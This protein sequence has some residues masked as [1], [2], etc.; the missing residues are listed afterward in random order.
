MELTD[1]KV[2]SY[3]FTESSNGYVVQVRR[4]SKAN[5]FI[6]FWSLEGDPTCWKGKADYPT[7]Q[8]C[9]NWLGRIA[10]V[11][12]AKEKAEMLISLRQIR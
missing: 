3:Y 2:G 7:D 5:V 11:K 9:S 8:F 4:I 6:N 1:F 12:I 10:W